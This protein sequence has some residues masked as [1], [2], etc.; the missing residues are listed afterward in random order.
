MS[1]AACIFPYMGRTRLTICHRRKPSSGAATTNTMASL[2][3]MVKEMTSAVI[4]ITG[5]RTAGRRPVATAFWTA[6]TSLVRR[7]TSDEV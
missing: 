4:I 2:A 1:M 6:V 5:E 3:L 7:V